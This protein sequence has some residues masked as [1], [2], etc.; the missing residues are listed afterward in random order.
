MDDEAILE[1]GVELTEC[2]E[3]SGLRDPMTMTVLIIMLLAG[4]TVLI[5]HLLGNWAILFTL[6]YIII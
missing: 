2:G 6:K 1:P 5:V 4:L 3:G